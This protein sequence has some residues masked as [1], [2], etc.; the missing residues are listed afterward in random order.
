[1]AKNTVIVISRN[2]E[3]YERRLKALNLPDLEILAPR[4]ADGIRQN[5]ERANIMLANPPLAKNYINDAENVKWMQST[6]AG[7]DAMNAEGL[8]KDYVLTNIR[9]VYGPPLAEYTFAYILAFRKEIS[10]NRAYQKE[11][12]WKQRLAGMISGQTLCVVGAGSIGKEIAKIGKAFGM[13]TIGYRSTNQ[14]IEFFDEIYAGDLKQCVALGD[15]VVS[16]LPNTKQTDDIFNAEVFASMK[17]T[18]VFINIGRGNAVNEVDLIAALKE[19]KIAKAVLDVFK[20]EPLP[21]DSPLWNTGNL[22]LTPHMAGYIFNDRELEIF[23]ENYRRFCAG[24]DL[25]YRVDFAKG[26]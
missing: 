16:V 1:M 10:E 18:A 13:R 23:A 14:P 20:A 17:N 26:Y 2:Q 24:E 22:Y 7:V 4:D 19:R 9:E 5:I 25:M 11:H 12:L 15:Y 3:E 8:R 21:A 6:Y